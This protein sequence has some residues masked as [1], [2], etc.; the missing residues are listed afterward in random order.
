MSEE[1]ATSEPPVTEGNKHFLA[2]FFFSFMWGAFGVDRFY[3]GKVGTGILKLITFGGLGI[4]VIIDLVLI[5]SG[6]MRDSHGHTLKDYQTYKKL[7]AR[8]VIWFAVITGISVLVSGLA[9]IW[10]IYSAANQFINGGGMDQFN[11]LEQ[12]SQSLNISQ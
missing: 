7:A 8:T 6:S 5:M 9:A 10:V 1:L 3:L 2:V 4:W 11:Q 12:Q